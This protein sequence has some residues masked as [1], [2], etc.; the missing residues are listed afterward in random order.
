MILLL[1]GIAWVVLIASLLVRAVRQ[2]GYYKVLTPD[3]NGST[4]LPMLAMIVPA[5]NE[6][7]NLPR[8]LE[9]LL[10]QDYPAEAYDIL[11][12]DDQSTDDT[13]EIVRAYAAKDSRVRLLSATPPP[14]GWAGKA[15]ACYEGAESVAG[16]A[17]LCFI[18]AD[19]TAAPALLK[20]A[21][22]RAI[23]SQIDMLSLSPTVELHSFWERLIVPAGF[24]L[25][26]FTQDVR[27]LDDAANDAAHADGQFLLIKREVYDEAGGFASVRSSVAED[28]AL[29][30]AVKRNGHRVALLG[31]QGL[32][33][34]RMYDELSALWEGLSRQASELL[35]STALLIVWAL[36][37]L[38]LGCASIALPTLAIMN[39]RQSGVHPI[40]VAA[41]V[42]AMAGGLSLL[43]THIGAARYFRIPMVYGALFPL[44]YT[45]GAALLFSAAYNRR[46]GVSRWKGRVYQ[47]ASLAPGKLSEDPITKDRA[48]G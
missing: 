43:G 42:L 44:S 41:L 10:A 33:W 3:L 17:W 38:V 2:Y 9:A 28:S 22:R 4:G 39:L 8:C 29:A 5:R 31:T 12:V 32:I 6:S 20:T 14:D 21:M 45:F 26:A 24:F 37:A 46:R 7:R 40:P 16:G 13:A 15:H 25:I 18:D 30:R 34:A 47:P 35:R 27:A 1:S 11:V 19:C 36:G 23:G 48:F